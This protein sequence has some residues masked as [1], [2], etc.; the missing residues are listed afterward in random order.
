MGKQQADDLLRELE[1]EKRKEAEAKKAQEEEE[2]RWALIAS[3][4]AT[5]CPKTAAALN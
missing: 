2:R 5:V 1:E 3:A 4:T